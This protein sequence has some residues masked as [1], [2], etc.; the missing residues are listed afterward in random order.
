M[1][2][3][4]DR[5]YSIFFRFW[6]NVGPLELGECVGE[7]QNR[8]FLAVFALNELDVHTE[9]LSATSGAQAS[10]STAGLRSPASDLTRLTFALDLLCAVCGGLICASVFK[11]K[12]VEPTTLPV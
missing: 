3:I 10:C 4:D 1:E 9:H 11:E 8:N 12:G 7:M 2:R 6:Q 5:G